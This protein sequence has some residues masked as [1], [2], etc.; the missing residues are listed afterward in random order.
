MNTRQGWW[1]ISGFLLAP[2]VAGLAWVLCSFV[3]G[4]H[5]S[6]SDDAIGSVLAVYIFSAPVIAIVGIPSLAVAHRINMVRWWVAA[7]I[8][9]VVGALFS[10][11]T[12]TS[13]QGSDLFR[14]ALTGFASA[15]FVWW[16]WHSAYG[17]KLGRH[18]T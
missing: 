4:M 17:P 11:F 3:I 12:F 15:L 6:G 7:V 1:L 18:G 9:F 16:C 10:F 14:F 5:F 8:G 13:G 2:L